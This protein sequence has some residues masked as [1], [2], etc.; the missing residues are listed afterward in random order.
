MCCRWAFGNIGASA[1]SAAKFMD[2]LFGH[3]VLLSKESI[4][5]MTTFG[6]GPVLPYETMEYG[7]CMRCQFWSIKKTRSPI[8]LFSFGG[9]KGLG[10]WRTS[11]L[12]MKDTWMNVSF[13]GLEPFLS[14]VGHAGDDVR[15]R[16]TCDFSFSCSILCWTCD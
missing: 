6:P 11:Q 3:P 10:V 5:E 7:T 1:V 13:P 12:A 16:H 14:Y 8:V 2:D 9:G 15:S 4:Q